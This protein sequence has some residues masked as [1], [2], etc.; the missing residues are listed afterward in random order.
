METFPRYWS[1]VRGIHRSPV[2]S[3]HKGQWR[4]A[5]IFYLICVWIN[6]WVNNRE[7]GD[8]RRYRAHYDVSVTC[9][10]FPQFQIAN[11]GQCGL[12]GDPFNENPRQNEAG[13]RY[14]NGIIVRTYTAG[15]T[16]G[17][18]VQI[19]AN[20]LVRAP[21]LLIHWGRVTHVGNLTIIGSNNGLSPGRR[22][23]IIWTN[24]GILLIRPLWRKFSEILIEIETFS[25]KKIRLQMSSEKCCQFRLSLNA[26]SHYY[27]LAV[28]VGAQRRFKK[29]EWTQLLSATKRRHDRGW[30]LPSANSGGG[31]TEVLKC[32]KLPPSSAGE[33]SVRH[34]ARSSVVS[35]IQ[36]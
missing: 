16:I 35:C 4:G 2:N 8:L 23:A 31:R 15:S 34:G 14:A 3:P 25:L 6:G 30:M 22:Q 9:N 7:A 12:C 29:R 20:H 13:G 5:L 10:V 26:L 1:F 32:S 11:G 18:T 17:V 24:A 19:T 36:L 21:I 33:I 28:F 27:T